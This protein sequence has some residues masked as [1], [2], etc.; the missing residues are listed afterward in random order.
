M[1]MVLNY[2]LGCGLVA[3]LIVQLGFALARLEGE[4]WLI[5]QIDHLILQC[6]SN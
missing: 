2:S 3:Y 1:T 5:C 6:W 4:C